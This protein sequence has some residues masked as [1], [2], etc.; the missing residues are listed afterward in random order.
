M[1][2]PVSVKLPSRLSPS[3]LKDYMQCPKLF[4]FKLLGLSTPGTEATSKGTLAHHVFERIFDNP[5]GGRSVEAALAYLLPAWNAMLD[6]MAVKDAALSVEEIRVRDANKLWREEHEVGSPSEA[7]L[8]A[9]AADYRSIITAE[10]EPAF[11]A[12][13]EECVRGWFKMEN[14]EKFDPEERELYV[15][16]KVAGVDLHGYIDRLDKLTSTTGD[17]YYISDYKT[18]RPPGE[19]FQDDAFFQLA[20]Y[21]LLVEKT[22]GVRP[23]QLRLI[24]VREGRP[25]AVLVRNVTPTLLAATQKKITA[26]WKEI[27]KSADS[28][29]WEPRKQTLCGWCFFQNVCPAYDPSASSL[30][31][32]EIAQ[33]TGARRN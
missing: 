11:L 8:L 5:R 2:N 30:T 32:D 15:T 26:T 9:E 18:G 27:K 12:A 31:V 28:E 20:L 19:K 23:F 22:M 33:R 29:T 14:P 21:A 1:N 3:R 4:Y 16:A 6:P 25:D 7:R 10:K 24:Y 13:T 17:R